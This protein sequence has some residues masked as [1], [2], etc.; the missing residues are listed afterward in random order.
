MF[1]T[2]TPDTTAYMIGGYAVFFGVI[3]IY[4]LSLFIRWVNLKRDIRTL[5]ELEEK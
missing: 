5:Q 3:A 4:L 1:T 2:A